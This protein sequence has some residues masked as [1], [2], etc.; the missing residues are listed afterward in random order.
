M[1]RAVIFDFDGTLANTLPLCYESFRRA[2]KELV[3]REPSNEE[4]EKC[5][6]PDDLGVIRLLLPENP[7]LHTK[8]KELF[9]KYY[10]TWHT[11]L[12]DK[13]YPH[14]EEVL[15]KLQQK[16]VRIAMVTGKAW[17]STEI[18]LRHYG[19]EKYFTIV[20]TGS[21][22][23]GI[24]PQKIK[25]VLRKLELSGAEALYVGDAL[26]DIDACKQVP[27]RIASVG[28]GEGVNLEALKARNTDYILQYVE[29]LPILVE[30]L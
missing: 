20:E 18:S 23:G 14:V 10:E 8:G 21:P 26:S 2:V 24:K 19:L 7:E 25:E 6:G 1:I 22:D 28:W 13:L 17:E 29:D 9:L 30:S 5:F 4:I 27:I 12:A 3:G 11:D 16:G 15:R